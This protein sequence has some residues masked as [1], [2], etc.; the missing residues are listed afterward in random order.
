MESY[1]RRLPH[2]HP[3]AKDLFLT[4]R[5][6]GS[7]PANRHISP[8]R[9]TT[10]EAFVCLDRCFDRAIHG[11]RWLERPEIAALV[12]NALYYGERKLEHYRLHAF[13][14]MCN[15]VHVLLSPLVAPPKILHTLKGFTA[16]QGNKLLNR[17]G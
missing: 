12:V 11:P 8:E 10:G 2:W 14:V 3:E 4:W 5:L 13:V 6:Y 17:T 7:L 16:R 15:H 1:E 9:V